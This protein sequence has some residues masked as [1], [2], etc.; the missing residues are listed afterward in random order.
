[1]SSN[2]LVAGVDTSTQSCKI[3]VRDLSTGKL[4]RSGNACHP[5]GTECHPDHWWDAFKEAAKSAGGL[6]D[7]E[8]ISVGGQ[9]HGMVLLDKDGEVIR[10]ALLWNDTRSAVAAEDLIAEFGA[11]IVV[12]SPAAAKDGEHL[13]EVGAKAWAENVGSVL[14]ASLTITKIRWV[15][16]HEPENAKRIHAICLPHDWLSWRIAGFGPKSQGLIPDFS[17]LFTDRSDASGTG[18][19][20]ATANGGVGEYRRDLLDLALRPADVTSENIILPRVLSPSEA[21]VVDDAANSDEQVV[22]PGTLIGPGGGDNAAAALGL[23]LRPGEVSVSLGTS[24]VV[25][26]V[27]ATPTND[28]TGAINGFADC[29]GNYLPLACTLNASR[30]V[31]AGCKILGVD[32]KKF[33]ELALEA[34]AGAGGLTLVPYFEGERMPNRPTANASLFG[35]TLANCTPAN[36]ARAFVEGMLLGLNDGIVQ[37]QNQG[38][39]VKKVYMIGGSMKS[40]AVR[41]I[42]PAI[43]GRD[44]TLPTLG[45]YVADGAAR[46]AGWVYNARNGLNNGDMPFWK[47]ADEEVIRGA[48]TPEVVK[49]YEK[50]N[51]LETK[52]EILSQTS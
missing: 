19:F 5:D 17:K 22:T 12:K 25:A 34:P 35:M 14:V 8:A 30:D 7:V 46:Q 1:M 51:A 13:T 47:L 38:V 41:A 15:A 27:S 31:D 24:G 37:M 6:K 18:Y 48:A 42:A 45:E 16:A 29:T 2:V 33:A 32:Y 50:M 44:I 4:V 40:P 26:A 21:E 10:P 36:M 3:V 43:F 23:G 52:G 11:E 39:L 28:Q 20:D 9:Q 49:E